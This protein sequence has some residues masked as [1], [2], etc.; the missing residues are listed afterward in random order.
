METAKLVVQE[1]RGAETPDRM[2]IGDSFA[3]FLSEVAPAGSEKSM[4]EDALAILGNAQV[5][6]TSPS[7]RTGL[8]VGRVQSGKTLSYESVISLARDNDFAL[9]VV[10]SGIS[11]PLL[12]QGVRRLRGDLAAAD[13]RG[14]TFMVNAG[15]DSMAESNLLTLRDNWLDPETPSSH[16]KTTVCLLLKNHG[17]IDKFVAACRRID[18]SGIKVLII[19]DEADQASMNTN[20]K[21]KRSSATYKQLLDMRQAFP[22]HA[23]L[24][25]TATPQAPLLV[26]I[27]D[28]L[29]PD[30]V[31]VIEPGSGYVGGQ[32]YFTNSTGGL[33]KVISEQDLQKGENA[34]GPPPDSLIQALMY[35]SLGGANLLTGKRAATRSMLIHPSRV[36]EPHATFARWVKAVRKLWLA[37]LDDPN[38][39]RDL[40]ASFERV[41]ADLMTTE[42]AIAALDDCWENM[43]YVL[44]NMQV[45]EMNTRG[46]SS[47]PAI[48]WDETRSYVLIGGQAL[49]RG[50]TVEGLSVT[51]MPRGP[52]L[53]NADSVQQRARFFGY[54]RSYLGQCR[55]YLEPQLR[56]A[57]AKYVEHERH[58][59]ESLRKIQR[60]TKTLKD[61]EREFYLDPRMKPTR[62]SVISV[63]TI[64]VDPREKWLFDPSPIVDDDINSKMLDAYGR[65]TGQFSYTTDEH[66][67]RWTLASIA[68]T[69][70]FLEA[71]P[72]HANS[73]VPNIRA[74]KLQLARSADEVGLQVKVG[75]MRPNIDSERSC[76]SSG[77]VQ[78]FQG[79]SKNYVGDRL[80]RDP[81]IVTMQIH[82]FRL[83]S[84]KDSPT[85]TRTVVP[86]L[87]LPESLAGGWMIETVG[88]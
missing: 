56:E 4:T 60:G 81:K 62:Q 88:S 37:A 53:W 82:R 83:R 52:G 77:R 85:T 26:A 20:P 15:S 21:S 50:F 40:R 58:M 80:L 32:E 23:Y 33:V 70:A 1:V 14:W 42:P 18:W 75:L 55:V 44:R 51:Y 66:G 86:A 67:H 84:S 63:P 24:Q 64:H 43:R 12:E 31:R 30:F 71:L 16:K 57:F 38:D 10:V 79:R 36:T 87:W 5:S 28:V 19:D 73:T 45:V 48:E 74:L 2:R 8:V 46:N 22:H 59:L 68:Q 61:W 3:G 41:H 54:K 7:S 29:S 6:S 35:F 49:D 17:R 13:E 65:W 25:Y 47:M 69:L 11:N 39:S 78:P 9:V 34:D 76:T 72:N 27:T